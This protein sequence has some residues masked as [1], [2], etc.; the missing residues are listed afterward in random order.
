MICSRGSS[1]INEGIATTP[2]SFNTWTGRNSESTLA[3]MDYHYT[4][5]L[6]RPLAHLWGVES[7][8]ISE[9]AHDLIHRQLLKARGDG[10]PGK[11]QQW[12]NL[13]TTCWPSRA[14]LAQPCGSQCPWCTWA[15]ETMRLS[16][17]HILRGEQVMPSSCWNGVRSHLRLRHGI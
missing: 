6:Y 13:Q 2:P 15:G 11:D 17:V 10:A 5:N 16:E 1:I 9:T 7:V 14:V 8:A 4:R 3:L 12:W